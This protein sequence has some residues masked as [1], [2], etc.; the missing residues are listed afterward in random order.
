MYIYIYISYKDYIF[1][2]YIYLEIYHIMYLSIFEKVS[3]KYI[4][5]YLVSFAVVQA[6]VTTAPALS[7]RGETRRPLTT[8]LKLVLSFGLSVATLF[9]FASACSR[10]RPLF[11]NVARAHATWPVVQPLAGR[12]YG[13]RWR[14]KSR[15]LVGQ[16]PRVTYTRS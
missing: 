10:A 2:I 8:S 1:N 5:A 7:L 14:G 6:S 9:S 15:P 13:R 16:R 3:S 11:L 12:A 4:K